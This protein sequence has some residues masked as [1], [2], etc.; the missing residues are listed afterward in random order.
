[1]VAVHGFT[2]SSEVWAPLAGWLGNR[3]RVLALD[4]PGHG[5]ASGVRADL[6]SGAALMAATC[7]QGAPA[8]ADGPAAWIGYSMGGRY[9][10]HVALAAPHMVSSLVLVSATAGFDTVAERAARREA[11]EV[12]ARRIERDGVAAFVRWWLARPLFAT[13]P[14]EAAA[15]DARLGNTVAGLASSLRLAGTGTQEPLWERLAAIDVPVLVTAG[16]LDTAYTER[17]ERLAG[18]I[19]ANATLAVVDGAGHACHL[20]RPAKWA[21]VVGPFLDASA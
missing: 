19:G 14:P 10:L 12:V 17:A 4:A 11:D 5:A 21:A 16:A 20:E 7:A 6:W 15:L 3:H 13:L 9:A 2:Q 1:M 18:A 8:G